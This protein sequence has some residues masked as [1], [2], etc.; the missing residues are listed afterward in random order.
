MEKVLLRLSALEDHVSTLE[1]NNTEL[2]KRLE[3]LAGR[4]FPLND[5]L[6]KMVET[7]QLG[8]VREK[9]NLTAQ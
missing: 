9:G 6:I 4:V 5:F 3:F 7:F 1:A 2:R 8:K